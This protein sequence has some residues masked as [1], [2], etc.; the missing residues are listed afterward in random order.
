MFARYM[1]QAGEN[2]RGPHAVRVL[3]AR[4]DF[5]PETMIAAAYDPYLTAFARLLP[6]LIAAHK[7]LPDGDPAKAALAGPVALLDGWD[8]HWGLQS[9]QTSLAVFWGEAL[10]PTISPDAKAAGLS[11]WDY[12]ATRATDAQK[13]AA[14]ASAVD[15]LTKDFGSWLVPWGEINRY[16]RNDGAIVQTFDDSKPSIAVPFTASQWGSLA[17][18]GAKRYPGTK[19][20]YGTLG[21]S[22][23]AAVEFGPRVKALAVSAGGESGDPASPHFGD[24]AERYV[25]GALRRVYFYPE[26]LKGHVERRYRPGE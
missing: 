14:L 3:S 18:F 17:A 5:T 21:N 12:A 7:A 11:V 4:S 2:P 8:Y 15:R 22:F 26:D 25:Q 19:R 23:V 24:Q 9:T 20:Y 1:D 10:W 16:Q 6:G 13:I